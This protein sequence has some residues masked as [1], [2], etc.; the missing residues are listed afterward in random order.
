MEKFR[1]G[2]CS[3]FPIINYNNGVCDWN[4]GDKREGIQAVK[5]Q[6]RHV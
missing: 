1:M 4:D 2:E 6:Y 3:A 5:K